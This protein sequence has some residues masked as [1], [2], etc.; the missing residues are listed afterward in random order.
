[1]INFVRD[2]LFE[3]KSEGWIYI[4]FLF[5]LMQIVIIF[6][7]F[8]SLLMLKRSLYIPLKQLIKINSNHIFRFKILVKYL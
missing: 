5:H 8:D 2:Q 3:R 6:D 7:S 4:D 1:M